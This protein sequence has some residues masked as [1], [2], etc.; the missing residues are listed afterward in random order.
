MLLLM[1]IRPSDVI[2]VGERPATH[3]WAQA[4]NERFQRVGRLAD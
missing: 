2:L 1:P 3:D 4:F